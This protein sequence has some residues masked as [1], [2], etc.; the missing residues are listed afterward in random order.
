MRMEEFKKKVVVGGMM[1][2]LAFLLVTPSMLLVKG[3]ATDSTTGKTTVNES[4]V[5]A[6]SKAK[7]VLDFLA[8]IGAQIAVA[9]G[10]DS[11]IVNLASASYSEASI[12]AE[13]VIAKAQ[14]GTVD[15]TTVTTTTTTL[16][17]AIDGLDYSKGSEA[18]TAAVVSTGETVAG[19]TSTTSS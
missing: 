15:E 12:L 1:F 3:C 19:S 6:L 16:L 9:A 18:V 13:A 8:P 11:T 7:A 10:A 2:S 14:D 17:K 4:V 5:S